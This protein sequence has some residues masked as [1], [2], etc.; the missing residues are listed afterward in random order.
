MENRIDTLKVRYC[1][2]PH[3][4]KD[5]IL[6]TFWQP[7]PLYRVTLT[8]EDYSKVTYFGTEDN[9]KDFWQ[10]CQRNQTVFEGTPVSTTSHEVE[11]KNGTYMVY[12]R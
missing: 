12:N 8:M 9:I 6:N 7:I 11:G 10:D 3:L 2:V 5:E 4:T 1:T